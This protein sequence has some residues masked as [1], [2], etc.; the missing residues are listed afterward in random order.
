MSGEKNVVRLAV[1]ISTAAVLA[2]VPASCRRPPVGA[3]PA[4]IALSDL[5]QFVCFSTDDNGSSGLPGSGS[6]GGLHYLTELFA[7][8]RNPAGTGSARTFDGTSPHYTFFVITGY[9]TTDEAGA[10]AR[11]YSRGDPPVFV[12]QAWR[13]AVD[14]G[15]EVGVHTHT[16]P[17]GRPLSIAQWEAE[18]RFS[19]EVLS[20]P[21]DPGESPDRP[22]P[23]SG[24]GLPRSAL[25]GFRT[26]Y[27]EWSDNGLAAT[28][29]QGFLY[30][31]SIED[32]PGLGPHRG[33]FVWPYLLDLGI[34]ENDPPVGR[35]SGLWEIPVLDF[36]APP[37]EECPRYGIPPGLRGALKERQEYFDPANGEITGM[38]WNL[39][40]EFFMT[41]AEFA[42][43]LKYTLDLHLAGNRSPMTVGLHSELYTVTG[44]GTTEASVILGRRAALEEFIDYSLAK[45]EA[46]L[47]D[48]RELLDWLA[49]PVGLR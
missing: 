14:K 12:K 27:L 20:R 16:H 42:A 2:L 23:A 34:P 45:P 43:T 22:N 19:F 15:H 26:P 3:A 48:H 5:P 24:L 10:A 4:G 40:N 29:K 6:E 38:D 32:G 1:L 7:A 33:E 13:E 37:D 47:V 39:W 49:R 28:A 36:V 11:E 17:H 25:S 9:L 31:S 41:P 44:G 35:H 18:M 21:W 46:R 30:D 8:R